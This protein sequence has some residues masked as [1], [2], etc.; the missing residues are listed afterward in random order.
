MFGLILFG[1]LSVSCTWIS[2]FLIRFRE[3]SAIILSNIFS[4]LFSLFSLSATPILQN[5]YIPVV[6]L[7]IPYTVL[8]F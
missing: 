6:V 5:V 4:T 1:T 7:D 3:F 2:V 8:I